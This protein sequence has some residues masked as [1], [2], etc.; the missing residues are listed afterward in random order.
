M[1]NR[2]IGWKPRS[3]DPRV[4]SSRLRCLDPLLELQSRGYS[5]E[6]FDP[7]HIDRYAAVIYSKAYDD[8]SYVEATSL[9]KR[10][11]RVVF[12]LCDNHFYNPKGLS[13]WKQAAQR[14]RRM[15]VTADELV[16]STE[17]LA[18]VMVEEL[19]DGRH[20]TVIG[21]AVDAEIRGWV[22]PVWQRW[23]H[24]R[25]LSRLL[26]KLGEDHERGIMPV[27]WFGNHGSPY[28]EGGM[29]DLVRIRPLL[30][31][32][33][34]RYPLTLT[35]ISNSRKKYHEAIEPW[36]ISTRYFPWH[37]ETFFRALRAHAIAVIPISVNP[38]T[39]CKSNNRLALSL[40]VGLA[41][42]A[43]SIPSYLAFREACYLDS[44][45]T[46]LETYLSN[47]ELRRRHV[48]IGRAIIARD[49]TLARIA[50]R[51][52]DLFD[53]LRAQP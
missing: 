24:E 6:T 13:Y 32:I 11:I 15:M 18:E 48:A 53:R 25:K 22:T 2:W 9:Q 45:E 38:F 46:G 20:V 50:D 43:D 31:K 23:F 1:D 10:G 49:W 5:V 17:A 16:A 28:A 33:N 3:T 47:P 7:N 34:R 39:R 30:E 8:L 51:W 41:V 35:V 21:D 19:S 44:W 27:I 12:D 36:S 52:H 37:P 26:E 14:L 40:H 42:V 4:A 29:L